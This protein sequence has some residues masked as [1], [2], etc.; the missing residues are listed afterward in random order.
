MPRAQDL[1]SG[2][3]L[4]IILLSLLNKSAE[5]FDVHQE[6][7]EKDL[8]ILKLVMDEHVIR[9]TEELDAINLAPS[10]SKRDGINL[11]KRV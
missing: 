2:A 3:V 1:L 9:F 5:T 7:T 6:W 8:A 10:R 4:I 11:R